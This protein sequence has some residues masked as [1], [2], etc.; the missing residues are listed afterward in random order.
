M[1][2][3]RL[4]HHHFRLQATMRWIYFLVVIS[5]A[6]VFGATYK[7]TRPV[8]DDSGKA[9]KCSYV[10]AYKSRNDA[11]FIRTRSSVS[12]LPDVKEGGTVTE[13]FDI[14]GKSVSVTHSIQEGKDRIRRIVVEADDVNKMAENRPQHS[15]I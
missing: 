10:L 1:G 14:V 9:F 2:T 15:W 8:T 7:E 13:S 11:R 12:C 6:L 3:A 4:E 5:P